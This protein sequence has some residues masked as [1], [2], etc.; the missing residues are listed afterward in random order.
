MARSV[1]ALLLVLI[2]AAPAAALDRPEQKLVRLTNRARVA[3]DLRRL[4]VGW[5]ITRRAERHARRLADAGRLWHSGSHPCHVW[6]ENVGY[7][8][9]IRRV[10]RAYM[11]SPAHR[12]NVLGWWSRIGVGVVRRGDRVWT[13]VVF[14][15]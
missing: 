10:H 9:T 3:H 5:K 8:A 4:D 1:L 12:A 11:R 2:L 14:C 13:T 6:G 15:R 7:G